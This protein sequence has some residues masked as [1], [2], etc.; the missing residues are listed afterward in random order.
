MGGAEPRFTPA[1]SRELEDA[2]DW[3]LE[4]S[5]KTAES[6]LQEFERG[7]ALVC[8]TPHLWPRFDFDTRRYILRRFPYSIIYRE[9]KEGVIE[10]V[11]VAPNR[12]KPGYWRHR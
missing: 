10:V 12:R 2:L 8:E 11:A 7:L 3:Y 9:P 6:F 4:R 5:V 1:A